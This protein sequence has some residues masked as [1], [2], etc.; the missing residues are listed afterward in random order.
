MSKFTDTFKELRE[1]IDAKGTPE[2]QDAQLE[3]LD[4]FVPTAHNT[5][6]G[7]KGFVNEMVTELRGHG[8][9]EEDV[10]SDTVPASR[11]EAEAD[12]LVEPKSDG[13]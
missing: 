7:L 8:E 13:E 9:E 11:E 2:D 1:Q 4:E 6:E 10:E 5:V 3:H 12:G